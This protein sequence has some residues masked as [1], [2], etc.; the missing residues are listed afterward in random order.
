M[1]LHVPHPAL[2]VALGVFVGSSIVH[3][4]KTSAAPAVVQVLA[5]TE[6][7]ALPEVVGHAGP[8]MADRVTV[9][10]T[11]A[12]DGRTSRVCLSGLVCGGDQGEVPCGPP[13]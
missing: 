11:A 12:A 1:P 6:A 5:R 10:R 9:A 4:R 13:C 3:A 2:A 7:Q 8:P